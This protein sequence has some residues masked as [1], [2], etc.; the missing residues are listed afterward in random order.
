MEYASRRRAS[1]V[2]VGA[3]FVNGASNA[4]QLY[5]DGEPQSM[6][7][8]R[9]A[10]QADQVSTEML[11]AALPSWPSF[12]TGAIDELAV[13]NTALAPDEVAA[14]YAAQAQWP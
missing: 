5:I 2:D 9:G 3:I 1:Y 11:I 8:L 14:I 13:W 10:P 6:S 4:T 12:Y 7:D